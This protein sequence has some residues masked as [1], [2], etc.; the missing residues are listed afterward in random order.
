MPLSWSAPLCIS[1]KNLFMR[2][3]RLR[4]SSQ[5]SAASLSLSRARSISGVCFLLEY[6]RPPSGSGLL[7]SSIMRL[8]VK[9][10]S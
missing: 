9:S 5:G 8:T 10:P 7:Q 3:L 4:I 2:A 1:S 6:A